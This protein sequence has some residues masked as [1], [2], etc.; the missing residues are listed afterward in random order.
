M[1]KLLYAFVVMGVAVLCMP[2][3]SNAQDTLY[4]PATPAGNINTVINGD[5]LAGGVRAHPNRVYRLRRGNVYQITEP[6]RINGNITIVAN[7]TTA[8]VRPP[9][10]APAILLDNSSVDHFFEFIGKGGQTKIN[11]VYMLSQRSDNVW[12]GW[13][14]CM[15]VSADSVS[16][17]LRGC[18]FEGFS[19]VAIN[20]SYWQKTDIQDCEFRNQA[21]TSSWFGGQVFRGPGTLALDTT[22]FINNTFFVNSSY[23]IDIRGYCPLAIFDHNTCAYGIA[24]PLLI[25][26]A[27]NYHMRDNIFYSMHGMGGIPDH[28]INGWFLNYPDTG[29]SGII[30]VRGQDS[31]S[32]WSKL[33]AT[34]FTG[35]NAWVDAAHGVTASMLDQTKWVYGVKNNDVFWPAKF[36]AFYK[37]WN[38]TV[39]TKDSTDVPVYGQPTETKM[40]LKR[41]LYLP[42]W[43]TAYGIWTNDSLG[44]KTSPNI[45]I[46]KTPLTLDPGFPDSVNN[47]VDKQISYVWQIATGAI[48]SV[49]W[50]FPDT[51]LYLPKWPLPEHFN[52]SNTAL[53]HAG[54]DGFA[55]GDLNWFPAQ[56]AQWALTGV[57]QKTNQ[58]PEGFAL[59]QNYP[60][61]FNP[62]TNID[63]SVPNQTNVTLKVFNLIG[64]E[65]STLVNEMKT[66]GTYRVSFDASKLSSGAYFYRL[67]AGNFTSVKK[68]VLVK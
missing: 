30:Q 11:N 28:V 57:E 31:V 32:Y 4:I 15:R 40:F 22:K 13:S 45:K 53:M 16:L 46:E 66:A 6:M 42:V 17:R 27:W 59:S 2:W 48:G 24:N 26:S 61:P 50:T 34:T 43:I 67:T 19:N 44:P 1:K 7:D 51:A 63:F 9:I 55:L 60:N 49:R 14:D 52:Y 58:V 41:K 47:Q 56:K 64:Q 54:H 20:P 12:L 23:L 39:V 38:D 35:P 21:H 10:L 37:S 68:M 33:W 18:Y 3:V 36:T 29:A 5:T 25:R 8:G 65:V 62:V